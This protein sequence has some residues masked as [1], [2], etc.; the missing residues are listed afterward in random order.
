MTLIQR[1]K[2]RRDKSEAEAH[3]AIRAVATIETVIKTGSGRALRTD[4][5]G[6]ERTLALGV[7]AARL[8]IFEKISTSSSGGIAEAIRTAGAS[9]LRRF[10][11]GTAVYHVGVGA[12][13]RS[14]ATAVGLGSH[15]ADDASVA[16]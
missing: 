6:T 5:A 10:Q 16:V 4:R 8:S 15:R 12:D 11:A 2:G 9:A 1:S 3:L 14:A 7:G 13:S